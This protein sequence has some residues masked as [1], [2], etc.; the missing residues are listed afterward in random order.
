MRKIAT[1]RGIAARIAARCAKATEPPASP[2]EPSSTQGQ[3]GVLFP[4]D[5]R[6]VGAIAVFA[7]WFGATAGVDTGAGLL[8]TPVDAG[9]AATPLLDG[10]DPVDA[11]GGAAAAETPVGVVDVPAAGA[12]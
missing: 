5:R 4:P 10:V 8:T 2:I 1:P 3:T 7:G 6:S 12:T 9:G 11:G